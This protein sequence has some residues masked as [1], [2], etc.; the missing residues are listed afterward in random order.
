MRLAFTKGS[1][2]YPHKANLGDIF[3]AISDSAFNILI[4]PSV[5]LL[6]VSIAK[7]CRMAKYKYD[8]DLKDREALHYY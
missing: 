8:V 2:W 7:I 5:T 6:L 3:I 1:V 4:V